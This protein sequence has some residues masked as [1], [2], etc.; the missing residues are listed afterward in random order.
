MKI[1]TPKTALSEALM[2]H[3]SIDALSQKQKIAFAMDCVYNVSLKKI[4]CPTDRVFLTEVQNTMNAI[5]NNEENALDGLALMIPIL[6]EMAT[7]LYHNTRQAMVDVKEYNNTMA[8]SHMTDAYLGLAELVYAFGSKQHSISSVHDI[9]RNTRQAYYWLTNS[10]ERE[11]FEM[12]FQQKKV[13][14]HLYC[15]EEK[16][17]KQTAKILQFK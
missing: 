1:N 6:S 2:L 13:E 15:M 10:L 12:H 9:A 11:K 16:K 7:E 14:K 3:H 4:F 8:A 5:L 17:Q